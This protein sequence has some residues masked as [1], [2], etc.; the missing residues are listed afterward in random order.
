M[1]GLIVNPTS[2]KDI[3]R[4]VALG[5]V[6]P[7]EEK[8]NVVARFLAGVGPDVPVL[9]LDDTAGVTRRAARLAA[10]HAGA[11]PDW[12]EVANTGTEADSINAARAL[13]ERGVDLVAV[14]GGDGTLRAAAEGWPDA[15]LLLLPAGTNNAFALPVEPTVAGVAAAAAVRDPAVLA[16]GRTRRPGLVVDTGDATT[17]AVVDVVGLRGRWLGGRAFWDPADLVEAVV[18]RADPSNIGMVAVAAAFGPLA[19]DH[20]RHLRFGPGRAVRVAFGPGLMADVAVAEVD[21]VPIGTAITLTDE[22]GVVALDGERRVVGG[23][24]R[25]LVTHGPHG[26]DVAAAMAVALRS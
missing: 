25:V 13:S 11:D 2:S 9:A 16:A 6:V 19:V 20:A 10:H 24:A 26:F 4:L 21:D 17:V 5:R 23:H 3:R 1:I 8:V 22:T 15:T 14:V 12:L 18:G 7:V